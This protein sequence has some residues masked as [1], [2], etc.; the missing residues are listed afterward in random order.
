MS[1][2]DK[3]RGKVV[4]DASYSMYE[5]ALV[6]TFDDGAQA[7]IKTGSASCHNDVWPTVK[8]TYSEEYV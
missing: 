5:D 8:L 4:H 1:D 6:I 3:I 2:L 7:I